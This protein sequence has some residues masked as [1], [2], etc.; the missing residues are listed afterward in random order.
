[1]YFTKV[2]L[3]GLTPVDLPI[4]NAKPSDIYILKG[5]DGLGPPEVD[6]S[7]TNT[8]NAG[9]F[10]QGRRPQPREVVARI[11]LNPNYKT[12]QSVA[13]LRTSLYGLLT[14]GAVDQVRI[15]L[16]DDT[17]LL[18]YATS[19]VKKLEISPFSKTPEVQVTLSCLQQYLLA[20]APLYIDPGPVGSPTINNIGTA[21]AGFTME[22]VFT[23]PQSV[24]SLTDAVGKFMTIFYSFVAGDRLIIDTRPGSRGI[25]VRKA[26]NELINII[27]ALSSPST[28]LMLHG[29]ANAFSI[30]VSTF[31]WGD[32][33]YHP[34]YWGI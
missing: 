29:G 24:F 20:P 9:G 23:A 22:V 15:E 30:N 3:N 18:V 2:R 12:N 32:V 14:P 28:W 13:D 16:Y 6:V 34:Q 5:A 31:T 27:Y 25:F 7:I 26:T 19:Y 8:L 4:V 1:M 33:S 11:G 21:P 17:T 10:Y